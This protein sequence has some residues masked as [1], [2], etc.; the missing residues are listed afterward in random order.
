MPFLRRRTFARSLVISSRSPT[1]LKTAKFLDDI[2]TLGFR[3]A[4]Q[5]GLSFS[6]NDLIIPDIKDQLLAN[7]KVEVDEVWETITWV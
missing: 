7:A 5:G 4:F 2:K 1:F 3:T 6:I